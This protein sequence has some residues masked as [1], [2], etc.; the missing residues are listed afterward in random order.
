V[1]SSSAVL[2]GPIG[3]PDFWAGGAKRG[4]CSIVASARSNPGV[5]RVAV[6][7]AGLFDNTMPR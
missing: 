3:Q 4:A 5:K 7:V 6:T 1:A 2:H